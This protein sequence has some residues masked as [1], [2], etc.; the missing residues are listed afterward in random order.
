MQHDISRKVK[1]F[2]EA[3]SFPG[4][5]DCDSVYGLRLKAERGI[6]A[7]L[8]DDQLPSGIRILDAGCG[9]GQ[10]AIFLSLKGRKV[11]GIDFSSNSLR[12]GNDFKKKFKLDNV[13]FMQ[14]SIFDMALKENS[15]D[16]VFCM[17]VLHHTHSA[18]DGFKVLCRLVKKNGYIVVGLYNKYGR[19]SSSVRKL[20]FKVVGE[21][22]QALD[23]FMRRGDMDSKKKKTWFMDQYRNPHESKHSVGE[24]L[25]WFKENKVE[26]INS[27]PKISLDEQFALGEKLFE[28]HDLGGKI[29]HFLSQLSW[30]FTQGKEGGFFIMIGRKTG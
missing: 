22:F 11:L 29:D 6:Y 7:K 18:Y 25:N 10:L 16:C 13:D 27:L 15:F 14:M 9:T 26:Y 1:L 21:R 5:D 24:V 23:Y 20:I 2:Y 30:M 19:I 17:G 4:Y 8:L 28:K 12:K 3:C